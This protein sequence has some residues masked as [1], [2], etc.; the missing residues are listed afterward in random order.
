MLELLLLRQAERKLGVCRR[1]A[2]AMPDLRN[3][4][5]IRHDMLELVIARAFAGYKDGND[6]NR[7]RHDP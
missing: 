4:G 6:I 5:W 1:I 7:L 3:P 2:E